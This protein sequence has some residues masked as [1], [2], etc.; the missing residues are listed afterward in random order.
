MTIRN[1]RGATGLACGIAFTPA[2]AL[3]YTDLLSSNHP[4]ELSMADLVEDSAVPSGANPSGAE[5]PP[6]RHAD[7]LPALPVAADPL[8]RILGYLLEYFPMFL[9]HFIPVFGGILTTIYVLIRDGIWPGQSVGKMVMKTQVI[10]LA[11]VVRLRALVVATTHSS[12]RRAGA[13]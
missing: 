3:A 8:E 7:G 9:V 4:G 1:L 6:P 13:R 11:R 2:L 5:R 10:V 12:G